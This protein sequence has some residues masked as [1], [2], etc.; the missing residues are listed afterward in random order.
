MVTGWAVPPDPPFKTAKERATEF[1]SR[2]YQ[3]A[4]SSLTDSLGQKSFTSDVQIAVPTTQAHIKKWRVLLWVALHLIVMLSALFSLA[5]HQSTSYPWL[6]N[7]ALAV[8]YL[9]TEELRRRDVW[10]ENDPW[11]PD[12]NNPDVKLSLADGGSSRRRIIVH[13]PAKKE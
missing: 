2:S 4:W 6:R 5:S 8:L 3:A 11:G 7:P 9:D 1:L 13:H 10:G 12:V